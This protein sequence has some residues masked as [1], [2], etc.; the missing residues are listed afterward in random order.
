[1]VLQTSG[2]IK[3]S[4][5]KT[6]FN[7]TT[8]QI[9]L[10]SFSDIYTVGRI[11]PS[12][13]INIGGF[14]SLTYISSEC[15]DFDAS[16]LINQ[17]YSVGNQITT[18]NAS[19]DD[20][21]TVNATGY[22]T[23]K[24]TLARDVNGYYEVS[25]V[26]ANGQYFQIPSI[27]FDFITNGGLTVAFVGKFASS[28][29]YERILD[30]GTSNPN[31]N[32]VLFRYIATN[33]LGFGTFEG[34][35]NQYLSYFSSTGVNSIPDTNHHIHIITFDNTGASPVYTYQLDG[36]VITSVNYSFAAGKPTNRTITTALGSANG[37]FIGK[38]N[39]GSGDFYLEGSI[40]EI[41][42]FKRKLTIAEMTGLYNTIRTKWGM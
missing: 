5:L 20:G 15:V 4:E 28:A 26:R 2:A 7:M 42:I 25:F 31:N 1:M 36:S 21:R 11:V 37:N 3:F 35:T 30:F 10:S 12:T 14:Y 23:T 22:G 17:G 16:K 29:S 32:I 9:S 18:W 41:K 27:T 39:W 40:R 6:E 24:P 8:T 33:S 13:N 38:S 19:N 34:T